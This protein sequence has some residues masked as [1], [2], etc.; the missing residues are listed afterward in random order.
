MISH[1][2]QAARPAVAWPPPPRSERDAGGQ[3]WRRTA[4]ARPE[5]KMR[6][7]ASIPGMMVCVCV[8][9]RPLVYDEAGNVTV[10]HEFENGGVKRPTGLK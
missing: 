4:I 7:A 8:S 1:D 10:T 6:W 3:Q 5:R 9:A 2:E